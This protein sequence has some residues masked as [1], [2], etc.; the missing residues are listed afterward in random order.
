MNM[1][2]IAYTVLALGAGLPQ[3]KTEK[4]AQAFAKTC[5]GFVIPIVDTKITDL[6]DSETI[7]E[8]GIEIDED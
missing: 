3:F 4:E 5:N 2:V 8:L 7:E 1:N 6:L